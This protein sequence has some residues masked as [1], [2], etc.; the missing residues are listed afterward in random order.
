MM[1]ICALK[2][3]AS[4]IKELRKALS[5]INHVFYTCVVNLSDQILMLENVMIMYT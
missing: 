2:V 5:C 3:F 1:N 4:F